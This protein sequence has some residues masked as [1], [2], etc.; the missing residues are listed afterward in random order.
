MKQLKNGWQAQGL[1][2]HENFLHGLAFNPHVQDWM[3]LS[4]D[5]EGRCVT[6]NAG[7]SLDL[8]D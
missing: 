4:W 1:F 8:A 2:Q 5:L 7:P 6:F 3:R